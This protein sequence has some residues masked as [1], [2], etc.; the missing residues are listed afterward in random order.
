[1]TP[2]I[3]ATA[4][5]QP[6][7]SR[8]VIGR[9]AC[10]WESMRCSAGGATTTVESAASAHTTVSG[11][12]TTTVESSVMTAHLSVFKSVKTFN[13][14]TRVCGRPYGTASGGVA[15]QK[16]LRRLAHTASHDSTSIS[17]VDRALTFDGPSAS[18]AA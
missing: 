7:F 9:L 4:T 3:T 17:E 14:T 6:I 10:S 11:G 13:P 15:V 16:R 18:R 5:P 8:H 2:T 12:E 1:M